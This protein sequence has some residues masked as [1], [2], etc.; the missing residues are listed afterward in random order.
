MVHVQADL[1]GDRIAILAEG[2]LRCCGTSLFLKNA[3][4][5]GYTLTICKSNTCNASAL[6]GVVREHIPEA[7]LV[8]NVGTECSFKLPV[9]ASGDFSKCFRAF[10]AHKAALGI[11]QYGCSITS[12]E[13]VFIT[14]AHHDPFEH[15]T[16]VIPDSMIVSEVTGQSSASTDF[17]DTRDDF[18][19][20]LD[21]D[22]CCCSFCRHFSALFCKRVRYGTR[23]KSAACCTSVFPVFMLLLGLLML[24]Y[25]T[26]MLEQNSLTLSAN[27][28]EPYGASEQL[29]V[30]FNSS[31][32]TVRLG[33]VSMPG[34]STPVTTALPVNLKV[35]K[36]TTT[37]Y[38][39][40]YT[41]DGLPTHS[42]R[43]RADRLPDYDQ[44]HI[45][46][47][48]LDGAVN[49]AA[50][51]LAMSQHVM[52]HNFGF[53]D[54]V[55]SFG[56]VLASQIDEG[57]SICDP[58]S[59][60]NNGVIYGDAFPI[61]RGSDGRY[62]KQACVKTIEAPLGRVVTIRFVSMPPRVATSHGV[63]DTVRIHHSSPEISIF[64]STTHHGN[65]VLAL[66]T[67]Q[68]KVTFTQ[69][70]GAP[71]VL[72]G[73][74][75]RWQW[76]AIITFEQ[77][78][79][80]Q[81]S[82]C[83]AAMQVLGQF[84]LSCT[85]P[86]D[87]V[88]VDTI[89]IPPEM[90]AQAQ[91]VGGAMLSEQQL[92]N[93]AKEQLRAQLGRF[94]G[95]NTLAE[96]CPVSCQTCSTYLG[97]VAETPL[98]FQCTGAEL[99][100]MQ[101][102]CVSAAAAPLAFCSSA[103]NTVR[104]S[105]WLKACNQHQAAAVAEMG[106]SGF[107]VG[108]AL[109]LAQ[110]CDITVSPPAAPS[111][112]EGC[113]QG[114]FSAERCCN[115]DPPNDPVEGNI[116]CWERA[117]RPQIEYGTPYTFSSCCV[118]ATQQQ[119]NAAYTILYNGTAK[120]A[121]AVYT[122]IITNSMNAGRGSITLHNHPFPPTASAQALVD[123]IASLQAVLFI[124]IAFAFVPGGVVVFVVREKESQ[125]NSK[126]QQMVSGVRIPAYWISNYA[127]DSALYMVPLGF[128]M[129]I[130]K[131]VDLHSFTEP[132]A[133]RACFVLLLG[134][135]WSI[136]PFTYCISF[137]YSSH[138][139]AQIF[140]VLFN[141]FLGMALMITHYVMSLI[142]DTQ[143]L[144][145]SLLPF[146]RLSPAFCLGHG[147]WQLSIQTLV[148][149]Y[150]GKG[151]VYSA[152]S[153]QIAGDDAF[154]LFILGPS[155]LLLAIAIDYCKSY[156]VI[157][158]QISRFTQA[159]LRKVV[160]EDVEVDEDVLAEAERVERAM[161][162]DIV[163]LDAAA[164]IVQ[165][166]RLRKVYPAGGAGWLKL[167][168]LVAIGSASYLGVVVMLQQAVW[169]AVT[170]TLAPIGIWGAVSKLR[171]QMS[172]RI[173]QQ[174]PKV[175]V[176]GVSFGIRSGECFGYL[177]INGAGKTSTMKMLTGD[178]L[179]TSGEARLDGMNV[180]TSQQ[181][182]RRL[183]GYCP[184][185][186]AL[187]DKLTVQEHLRLFARVRGVFRKDLDRVVASVMRRMDLSTFANKLA[188]TLSGGNKRKLSVGIALIGGPKV[189]L[190]DEPTTG[191]DPVARRFLW[192]VISSLA[193][194]QSCAVILTTHV[195]EE[196][197]ALCTRVGE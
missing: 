59:I 110:Q 21:R 99:S 38:G 186:D 187:L 45:P 172:Q 183:I 22:R 146:Y 178:T 164:D 27:M 87:S 191:V 170:I 52:S 71:T 120:H 80:D 177:G 13:E 5:A 126:H 140:T 152:L 197:E 118:N 81:D 111:A 42:W 49:N 1:L 93:A 145:T 131:L 91:N 106:L 23:D 196:V 101:G 166:L 151:E 37:V 190:L 82:N 6:I 92:R 162:S 17:V 134:F 66:R 35:A 117:S 84:K 73:S 34:D 150:L 163:D 36:T 194:Q 181:A 159:S 174:R 77:S 95:A 143:D 192:N 67:G 57:T 105:P 15:D 129:L 179:P 9:S 18:G 158:M 96:V 169:V 3:F 107:L 109:A 64:D 54:G 28:F 7:T 182:C 33:P 31:R 123:S 39:V 56:A 85:T 189:V 141:I 195:M 125:H 133:Y 29:K 10:D 185:F 41:A 130:I 104:L 176:R 171:G 180:L 79:Q 20:V 139:R 132:S 55:K 148:H 121:E 175:A 161:A 32:P 155:Y 173:H 149:Q 12:M 46:A 16:A 90:L 136:A 11:E 144:N 113:W 157:A 61:S 14:V 128:S 94:G 165:V 62:T 88:D 156:P 68:R 119:N 154:R 102:L 160:D 75:A 103:C 76:S 114:Q 63:S 30:P 124:L 108:S 8:S 70:P 138:T 98:Q 168:L 127:W 78:C 86:L 97:P 72:I 60:L 112:P 44:R 193:A 153:P 2:Q 4:G 47:N 147:L 115:I 142:P 167:L 116:A 184:Q 25:A 50:S 74:L 48:R 19:T 24:K 53:A 26:G 43:P 83:E 100:A 65:T 137:L 69:E 58:S 135:G 122:N 51:V 40:Q 89:V 188:S